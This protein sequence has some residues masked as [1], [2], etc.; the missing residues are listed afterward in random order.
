MRRF[1]GTVLALA[2]WQAILAWQPGPPTGRPARPDLGVA[3]ISITPRYPS[4]APVMVAGV[5]RAADPATGRVVSPERAAAIRHAPRE[6]ERVTFTA[7]VA[8][9]GGAA[10]GPFLY[11]WSWDGKVI[12]RGQHAGLA[13]DCQATD[14]SSP[15]RLGRGELMTVSLRAG[16]YADVALRRRWQTGAHKI[17]FEVYPQA[18]TEEATRQNNQLEERVDALSLVVAVRRRD[19]NAFTRLPNARSSFC[20]EDWVHQHLDLLRRKFR[21][22]VYDSAPDG[23]REDLRLDAVLILDDAQPAGALAALRAAGGWDCAWEPTDLGRSFSAPEVPDWR[24]LSEW[25]R[26]LGLID[27]GGLAVEPERNEVPDPMTGSR[28]GLGHPPM[29][30]GIMM[31]AGDLPFS[32][33]C[34]NALNRQLGRRRGYAGSHLFD[35]P[36]VC[37]LA[38]LDN[39]GRPLAGARLT[40]YQ[41]HEG[42]VLDHQAFAGETDSEGVV[43]LPNRPAT[44]VTTENGFT[45]RDNPF[46]TIDPAGRNGA[47]LVRIESRGRVEHPRV[48]ITAYNLLFWKGQRSI[49]TLL[50]P[51]RLAPAD[52]PPAPTGLTAALRRAGGSTEVLVNWIPAPAANLGGYF[53]YRAAHPTYQLRRVGVVTPPRATAGFVDGDLPGLPSGHPLRYA[54]TTVTLDGKESDL[55][56]VVQLSPSL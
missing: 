8:N 52:S 30:G 31:A 49:A 55:S 2:A 19:Y 41:T 14:Q 10:T 15:L 21:E 32:E 17:R 46:G 25:G 28:L 27:L 7:R 51:T 12:E 34:V 29:A 53:V 35:L 33:H 1:N 16:T 45:L 42:R 22:S 36:R 47:F 44:R 20:F 43:A 18:E 9:Q 11:V 54:V 5:P 26:Q 6:G 50:I 37:R 56:E 40:G 13:A 24:V 3:S 48:E 38:V 23:I 4:F 39:E